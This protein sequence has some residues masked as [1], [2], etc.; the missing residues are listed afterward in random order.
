MPKKKRPRRG[1][2]GFYPRKR[3]KRIYP[4]V[5][6]TSLKEVKPLGFAGYKAGMTHVIITDSNPN[7]ITQSQE[8]M[9]PIT[10]LE[11]P[12]LSVFG[13]RFYAD[14]TH[15]FFAD[16]LDKKLK[17]KSTKLPKPKKPEKIPENIKQ[18]VLL[19]HTNPN[20]KKKPEIFEIP[21]GGSIEEQINF[22]KE[23][24]GK[25]I[26]VKQVFKEGDM[27]DVSA[28]TTGK[29]F[30]G[31]VKRFG[32]KILGRKAQQMQRHT[33]ALGPKEPGKVRSTVPQAGQM[34]FQKR[35]E[36]NKRILKIE[37]GFEIKG[38]I[39]NFGNVKSECLLI[40]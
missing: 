31:P 7:S 1:S 15:D 21:I 3:A 6:H 18:I 11:C 35:T 34:G 28:I 37:D 22:A 14:N 4:R 38:G 26:S 24:L 29:G 39:V 27:I 17:R 25:Q 40:E 20:F 13:F 10:I 19:C 30:Q 8:I 23:N 9:K 5:K 32:V 33:G 2:M 16:K 36:L 12:S